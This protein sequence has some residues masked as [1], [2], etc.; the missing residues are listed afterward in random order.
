MGRFALVLFS[1]L[2]L[3]ACSSAPAQVGS[4]SPQALVTSGGDVSGNYQIFSSTPDV[5]YVDTTSGDIT[6]TS[7][8]SG[9]GTPNN[10]MEIKVIQSAG[11]N[12]VIF[13]PGGSWTINGM[14]SIDLT[15]AAGKRRDIRLKLQA[16]G[17]WTTL[18]GEL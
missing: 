17:N 5:L 6:L 18:G 15:T 12:K 10:G 7:R 3:A 4:L 11:S 1:V 2:A 16:S 9:P 14:S 8:T 13:A